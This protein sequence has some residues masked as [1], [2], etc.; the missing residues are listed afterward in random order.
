VKRIPV[1]GGAVTVMSTAVTGMGQTLQTDGT[2]LFFAANN[3]GNTA[4]EIKYMLKSAAAGTAPAVYV[5]NCGTCAA[6]VVGGPNM[7]WW[8]SGNN[9]ISSAPSG[10]GGI[11]TVVSSVTAEP[12]N[13]AF[14]ANRVWWASGGTYFSA[15]TNVGVT[16]PSDHG[17]WFNGSAPTFL[18]FNG[19]SVYALQQANSWIHRFATDFSSI[20]VM[21]NMIPGTNS[22]ALAFDGTFMYFADSS[23]P[24]KIRRI[25]K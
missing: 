22:K 8:N 5:A 17:G 14:G 4:K 1:G 3:A 13:L 20:T 18:T 23:N 21:T 11:A 15:A 25:N 24:T 19:S 9:T 10:G 12:Y 2:Y 16:T 7:Y 6:F